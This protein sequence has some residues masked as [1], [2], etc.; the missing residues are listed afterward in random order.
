M[1]AS[2][3]NYRAVSHLYLNYYYAWITVGKVALVTIARKKLK[4][5]DRDTPDINE[6]ANR[7]ANG[8]MK[9]AKKTLQLFE[10]LTRNRKTTRF[11]F[12]DFQGCSIAIIVTLVA[13]IFIRDSGY[14]TRVEFGLSCLRKMA[15]GNMTAK[16]G[17]RFVEAVRSI[18]DEAAT[19][20]KRDS[21][22]IR[23][24]SELNIHS[25]YSDWAG[26]LTAQESS[27]RRDYVAR[28]QANFLPSR[29]DNGRYLDPWL[30]ALPAPSGGTS[31]WNPEPDTSS[32]IPGGL[33]DSESPTASHPLELDFLST[34][35]NDD[36][37][38]LMGLTGLDAL[39]FSGLTVQLE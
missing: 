21:L 2:D 17:V 10:N 7:L 33:N 36:Q 29:E 3:F 12:T 30:G 13:G 22:L 39:D 31:S 34:L 15:T 32:I 4:Q 5:S 14:D 18:T 37:S 25:G 35:H 1:S 16:L 24:T 20:L 28:T 9:A 23:D 27:A 6:K 26:W 38:F 8:C 11:S 19:K